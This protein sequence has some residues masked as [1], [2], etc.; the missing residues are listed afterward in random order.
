MPKLFRPF[1]IDF[2][3][4]KNYEN[5]FLDVD[6]TGSFV[7]EETG[8]KITIPG[9]WKG[10]DTYTLR[11]SAPKL[12]RW[13]YVVESNEPSLNTAGSF[14][15]TKNFGETELD[16]RGFV[17]ISDKGRYFEYADGTPFYWMGDTNWQAPDIH[18]IDE[19]N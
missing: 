2:K 8:E 7:H 14:T 5:P 11:F 4:E 1:D 19:C 3:S 17:K 18:R 15:A 10:G 16:R 6:V 13:N 9:F 12:G